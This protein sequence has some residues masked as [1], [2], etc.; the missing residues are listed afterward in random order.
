MITIALFGGPLV[1]V[2]ARLVF[3]AYFTAKA[4]Y[5]RELI[6]HLSRGEE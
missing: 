2:T 5:Q 4:A 3:A 6:D 1:Y